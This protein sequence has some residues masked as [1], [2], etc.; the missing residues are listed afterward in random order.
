MTKPTR[1][2]SPIIM[3]SLGLAVCA[4]TPDHHPRHRAPVDLLNRIAQSNPT[5]LA[6]EAPAVR[7]FSTGLRVSPSKFGAD[8]TGRKDSWAALNASIGV[9]LAQSKLSPN[10]NFPGDTS[11]GNG[12]AIRDMGGC[13]IDLGAT[14]R[15]ACCR[16]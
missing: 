9:C 2:Q 6:L 12:K 14:D 5:S 11:F 8:P 10:G 4:L 15:C 13:S 1:N 7:S 3:L 16:A